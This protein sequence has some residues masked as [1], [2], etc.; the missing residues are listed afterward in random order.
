MADCVILYQVSDA[1]ASEEADDSD[2]DYSSEDENASDEEY[3]DELDS[4][5]SSGKDWSDLEREAEE[6]DE[7]HEDEERR[8]RPL[9]ATLGYDPDGTAYIRYINK[10]KLQV[11]SKKCFLHIIQQIVQY[12]AFPHQ[13]FCTGP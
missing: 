10:R 5:E 2:D 7:E 1:S 9:S 13:S 6:D 3:N 4:D 11:A 8:G 12:K